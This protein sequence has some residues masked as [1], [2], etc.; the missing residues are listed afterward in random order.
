VCPQKGSRITHQ[1]MQIRGLLI[2]QQNAEAT[3]EAA[4]VNQEAL[5][6]AGDE[7]FRAGTYHISSGKK[8]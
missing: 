7:R 3:K 4:R 2:A 8:W 1:L 5:I 6:A